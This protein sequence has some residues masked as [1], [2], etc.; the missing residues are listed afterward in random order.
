MIS[1]LKE[2]K[3]NKEIQDWDTSDP[4]VPV[5]QGHR[6][7][8]K[9]KLPSLLPWREL[10]NQPRPMSPLSSEKCLSQGQLI[11]CWTA[12]TTDGPKPFLCPWAGQ[13][14]QKKMTD[15]Q[16]NN[17]QWSHASNHLP[18]TVPHGG[19]N[20]NPR[21]SISFSLS[22]QGSYA[23]SSGWQQFVDVGLGSR[24][25]T[26]LLRNKCLGYKRLQKQYRFVISFQIIYFIP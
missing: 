2:I 23:H 9:W 15:A 4:H 3:H 13:P 7:F 22:H 11:G 17:E 10:K 1:A 5:P 26:R 24:T 6:F 8:F 14:V 16:I 25:F 20:S 12:S 19:D 18:R 21:W